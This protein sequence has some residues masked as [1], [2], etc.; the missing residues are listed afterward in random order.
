M[1]GLVLVAGHV[2]AM[3]WDI[4]FASI[5]ERIMVGIVLLLGL[6]RLDYEGLLIECRQPSGR[7]P[8]V[9]FACLHLL[10][11]FIILPEFMYVRAVRPPKRPRTRSPETAS[12]AR[13]R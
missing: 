2:V 12:P 10:G 3:R 6:P 11:L 7:S 9:V 13:G 5:C 1:S 8:V 4:P